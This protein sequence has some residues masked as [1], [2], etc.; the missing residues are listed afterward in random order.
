M[1]RITKADDE[2]DQRDLDEEKA[3]LKSDIRN[4]NL[5]LNK[6]TKKRKYK[7]IMDK[8]RSEEEGGKQKKKRKVE[9]ND[10]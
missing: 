8:E 1:I 10:Y 2:G 9:K 7:E 3:D 4:L 5:L 6:K